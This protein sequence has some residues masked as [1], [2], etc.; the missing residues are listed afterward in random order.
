MSEPFRSEHNHVI[1]RH[2]MGSTLVLLSLF[3]VVSI[4]LFSGLWLVREL[5]PQ[6]TWPSYATIQQN[7]HLTASWWRWILGDVTEVVFYK[8]EFA[9]IGLIV[10]AAV[11]HWAGRQ[12]KRWAGFPICYG[13]GL[14]PWLFISSLSGLLLSSLLWGWT[15]SKQDWQPTFVAFV[16]L[17]AAMVL[18]FG[19]GW[20]VAITGA[21]MGA[22]LV[23]PAA[24]LIVNYVCKPLDLPL[25]I[26][27][28]LGMASASILAFLLCRW[29]P[30]L[31]RTIEP[32][33]AKSP[34][35]AASPV[36]T[37]D[38]GVLWIVRRILADFSEAPFLGNELASLGLLLGVG[39]AFMLNP[40]SPAY[41]S[42]LLPDLIAGQLLAATIGVLV[43]R[44]QWIRRGWYPTYIPLVSVVPATI[45]M[46]GGGALTIV[47]S[48]LAGA[49][50][51]P[52]LA[53][54]I[55]ARLPKDMH[56]YIANVL[57]MAVSTLLIVPSI[58]L[59]SAWA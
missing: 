48:A 27:N 40:E 19:R 45:L 53:A 56:S 16:S 43:W 31:V 9:S 21:V 20:K 41:G 34:L 59:I 36:Q 6:A 49:L 4:T 46:H 39:L 32:T 33:K 17:P 47:M 44:K 52:P 23:T 3:A 10:G 42:G 55:A 24:L 12:G 14:W 1:Y 35:A 38:F 51:A 26:G 50:I 57:S 54:T 7:L 30:Q 11:A 13:T 5:Q 58:G 28:V 8:H 2:F 22:L 18:L 37:K 15:L 25:V 29:W